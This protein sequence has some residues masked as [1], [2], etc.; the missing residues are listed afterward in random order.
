MPRKKSENTPEIDLSGLTSDIVNTLSEIVIV[1]GLSGKIVYVNKA[2]VLSFG[3]KPRELIGQ[4]P[5]VLYPNEGKKLLPG[6]LKLILQGKEYT[7][8]WE[9]RKKDGS[10][11]WLDITTSVLKEKNAPVGFIGISKDVTAQVA[12]EKRLQES[13]RMLRSVVS[14]VPV[15]IFMTDKDGL[16]T[17]VN[18]KWC[19]IAGLTP[20][21]AKGRGWEK[22]LHPDDRIL[23]YDAWYKAAPENKL[24]NLTYR[25]RSPSGKVTWV[26]GNATGMFDEKGLHTGYIGTVS[27]ISERKRVEDEVTRQKE[28]M[29]LITDTLPVLI[30]YVDKSGR[31]RFNN[32]AYSEWFGHTKHELS[33][34]HMRDVLGK[35][36]YSALRQYIKRVLHGEKVVYEALVPYKSGTRYVRAEYI[37]HRVGKDVVG[38][39][40][41]VSD[42]SGEKTARDIRARLAAIVESSEDAIISKDL[43]GV[44]TSWNKGAERL[45]GYTPD[46]IIGKS[47]S[48]LIPPDKKNDF[49]KIMRL[50]RAGKRIDGYETKRKTKD[51]R[52]IDVSLTISP[53]RDRHGRI[54]GASKIARDITEDRVTQRYRAR[55]AAIVESSE[56]A[57]LSRD[58]KGTILT[59]NKGAER[60]FGYT[61]SEAIGKHIFFLFPSDKKHEFVRTN[62]LLRRG[63]YFFE[64]TRIR[65]DGSPVEVSAN[66]SPILDAKGKVTGIS[67][68]AR[69]ITQQKQVER[70][71][72]FLSEAGKLLASPVNYEE[73]LKSVV[74]AAVPDIADWCVVDLLDDNGIP[75]TIEIAHRESGKV[76]WARRINRLHPPG[77]TAKYALPDIMKRKSLIFE[78]VITDA[79]LKKSAVNKVEL[80]LMRKLG[81]VSVIVVP[82]RAKQRIVGAITLL[83]A[84]SK[85]KLSSFDVHIAEQLSE[86]A[87]LAIENAR[88]YKAI[89]DERIHLRNLLSNVPGVVWEAYGRPDKTSQKIDFVSDY[90]EK[91]LGYSM[92]EW[93]TTPNFWYTIVHPD[94]KERAAREAAAIFKSGGG[95][96]SRFRWVARNGRS[97]WVEAQ[98]TVIKDENGTSIGMRGVTMDITERIR[99]EEEIR[100]S[101]EK[102]RGVV[103]NT[104]DLISLIGV[105]GKTLYISP[106]H[107]EILGYDTDNYREFILTDVIHPDDLERVKK[108]MAKALRG[109]ASEVLSR[110][111]H[112]D[113]SWRTLEAKL[114]PIKDS[115][116]RV[117]MLLSSARDVTERVEFEKRKDEFISMASHELKTPVTSLKVYTQLLDRQAE[118]TDV[119]QV[120]TYISKMNSQIDKLT[121]LIADLLDLSKIQAGKLAF[122]EEE[123]DLNELVHELIESERQLDRNHTIV[124]EGRRPNRI[125]ADRDRIGQVLIN[126]LTNARKYSPKDSKI[127]VRVRK[128]STHV[129]V[130]VQDF[131]IGIAK[132]HQDRIFERFYQVTDMA[133][134]TYPGLG[135]GLYISS[136][137]IRRHKGRIWVESQKGKG[138]TFSFSLPLKSKV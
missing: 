105:D 75:R 38:F 33:G 107:E 102:Y 35:K 81:V 108:H 36:A 44:I 4:T 91:M 123:F 62:I 76:T 136:E 129:T 28:Q 24:F 93:L 23:V 19:D 55:L 106:S 46:E 57:I 32:Q 90:V 25:F 67:V 119:L 3:Y 135:I 42:I 137:I 65:K 63:T 2:A 14:A 51:G 111:R 37:P 83:T 109:A 134:K 99:A 68:I 120:K 84:D 71:I 110:I 64:T 82:L 41:L 8:R 74:R 7:G 94:D 56:D 16:C 6:D 103:E 20:R 138:S 77:L 86:R 1:T 26:H 124:E 125:R 95:G 114:T 126:L 127:I 112:G 18:K 17:Y 60:L 53:L 92:E 100:Q 61:A 128:N 69:N 87:S 72:R 54:V 88:L 48:V 130:S 27:D 66:V 52:V 34:M 11:I 30:S 121:N 50:L 70:S 96:V 80:A 10:V 89:E 113:G 39:Y 78:P 31:Y 85:R 22:A 117:R 13:E 131:G 116:G 79:M 40:A 15:G 101:E 104:R 47:V 133:E 29:D 43:S 12:A 73:S 118:K 97:F 58:L 122:K 49:P 21:Q 5:A 9:G 98:S 59:W 132:S 115:E 45:Y